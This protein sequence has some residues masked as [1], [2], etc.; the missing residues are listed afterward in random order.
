MPGD[1]EQPT[2][3]QKHIG[4]GL[5]SYSGFLSHKYVKQPWI[6]LKLGIKWED[7]RKGITMQEAI[8]VSVHA[9]T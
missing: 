7:I 6:A 3:T 2:G 5:C 8:K 4:A 1:A 9:V